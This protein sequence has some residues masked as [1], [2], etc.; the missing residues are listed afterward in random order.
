MYLSSNAGGGFHIWR[1]RF[2]D[3]QPEQVTFGPG[4]EEGIA[5]APDGKSFITAA[6]LVQS[7][8]WIQ[9]SSGERQ[10]SL[11]GYS[12]DV[13]FTPDGKKLCYRILKGSLPVSD[14]SDL[15]V[16]ELDSGRSQPLL[17]GFPVTGRWGV[18][19]DISPDGHKV[20]A[21]VV[22]GEGRYRLWVAPLDRSYAPRQIPNVEGQRPVFGPRGEIFF[23]SILGTSSSISRVQ[24]DGTGLRQAVVGEKG[25]HP[26]GISPDGNWLAVRVGGQGPIVV[27]YPLSAGSP[28]PILGAHACSGDPTVRWSPDGR[29]LVISVPTTALGSVG[30][31]YLVPLPRGRWFPQMPAGGFQSEAD[32]A[33]LPGVRRVDAFDVAASSR[34]GAYAF[35]RESVQRNLF[36]VPLS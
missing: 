15:R 20:V 2:P 11:E 24:E 28:V 22:D 33:K 6:G 29:L 34:P 13:K 26:T 35:A 8:V 9:D 3:G 25:G 23:R 4:D 18:A 21:A 30:R 17:P 31:T 19:Y 5:M 32:I 12:F 16:L 7:S 27:A 36:R 14:P 1:Q 10:V